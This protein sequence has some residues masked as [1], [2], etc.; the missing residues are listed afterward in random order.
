MRTGNKSPKYLQIVNH[1]DGVTNIK[2][3]NVRNSK[4][5]AEFIEV[6]THLKMHC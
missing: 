5:K 6:P 2:R 1:A 4:K 3:E